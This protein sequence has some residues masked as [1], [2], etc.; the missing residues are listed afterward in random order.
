MKT[1]FRSRGKPNGENVTPRGD[2]SD[3]FKLSRRQALVLVLAQHVTLVDAVLLCAAHVAPP[4]IAISMVTAFISSRR[5]F[6]GLIE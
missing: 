2:K 3:Q 6:D 1:W 5:F 4:V